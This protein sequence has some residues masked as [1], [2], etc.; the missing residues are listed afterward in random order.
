MYSDPQKASDMTRAAD[1]PRSADLNAACGFRLCLTAMGLAVLA[2]VLAPT[3]FASIFATFLLIAG[4]VRGT[5]AAIGQ[6][7]FWADHLN[8]WDE[9][10]ILFFLG[11]LTHFAGQF[12]SGL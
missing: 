3:G 11:L 2:S 6:D 12:F 5:A 7:P 9:T 4:I 1:G 10:I 8:R